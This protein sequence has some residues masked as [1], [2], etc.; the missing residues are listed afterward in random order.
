[1]QKM[2]RVFLADKQDNE[3]FD[4]LDNCPTK[5]K[6]SIIQN[7]I[8]PLMNLRRGK[9]E[10]L[11]TEEI[12]EKLER[13]GGSGKAGEE[14]ELWNELFAKVNDTITPEIACEIADIAYYGLQPNIN[15]ADSFE[16]LLESTNINFIFWNDA[17][18]TNFLD[19]C[20]IKYTT[21]LEYGN[22]ENYKEIEFKKMERYL[23]LH[24]DL[25][26]TWVVKGN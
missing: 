8:I 16:N 10:S 20:I 9:N 4:F 15:E 11:T 24:P 1:M 23:N 22:Q 5:V 17:P 25:R 19:F 2:E 26:D 6:I 12:H 21:R 14:V 13:P 3:W 18:I 7:E